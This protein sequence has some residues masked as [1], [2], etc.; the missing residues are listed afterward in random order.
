MGL[1][2]L[3]MPRV[4]V[5]QCLG[6]Q[7]PDVRLGEVRELKRRSAA[8][9]SI[10]I[11]R[12]SR[13]ALGWR[14]AATA[15]QAPRTGP[16]RRPVEPPCKLHTDR[17]QCPSVHALRE[18]RE[19]PPTASRVAWSSRQ[20]AS[21]LMSRSRQ[22]ARARTTERVG[23][24]GRTARTRHQIAGSNGS[25]ASLSVTNSLTRKTRTIP[26]WRRNAV[27]SKPHVQRIVMSKSRPSGYSRG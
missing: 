3:A 21:I 9:P 20:A 1:G 5:R 23:V 15:V 12:R 14:Q 10:R 19:R 27:T 6:S 13:A 25:N 7:A 24:P 2:I 4:D 18:P 17:G 11:Q 8:V 26:Y 16:P 22:H